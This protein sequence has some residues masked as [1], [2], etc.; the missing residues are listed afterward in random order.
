MLSLCSPGSPDAWPG[1]VEA[2]RYAGSHFVYRVTVV[3]PSR[4]DEPAHTFEVVSEDGSFVERDGVGVK[5]LPKPVALLA[6]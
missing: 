3:P 5:L 1:Q 6:S 2:R 4:G